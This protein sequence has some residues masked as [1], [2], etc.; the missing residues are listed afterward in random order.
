MQSNSVTL[1]WANIADI[2]RRN[3]AD[4]I[5]RQHRNIGRYISVCRY[6]GRFDLTVTSRH[7]TCIY[8]RN[9]RLKLVTIASWQLIALF[10]WTKYSRSTPSSTV[11]HLEIYDMPMEFPARQVYSPASYRL[12]FFKVKVCKSSSAEFTPAFCISTKSYKLTCT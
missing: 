6:I 2:Y 3:F 1:L 12:T 9:C 10:S 11:S 4:T 7:S 8:T 5:H